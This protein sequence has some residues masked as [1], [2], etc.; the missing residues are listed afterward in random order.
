MHKTDVEN[1]GYQDAA[2]DAPPP[3]MSDNDCTMATGLP[4]CDVAAGMCVQCLGSGDCSGS[5]AI[6]NLGTHMCAGCVT[7]A[8]CTT[9]GAC[10]LNGTCADA[11]AVLYVDG[12]AGSNA[13]TC[14]KAAPCKT[15]TFAQSVAAGKT[16][17]KLANTISDVVAIPA[18]P[19]VFLADPS[20]KITNA[21]MDVVT[22]AAGGDVTMV[23]V[24]VDCALDAKSGITSA[25]ATLRLHHITV[26]NCGKPAILT[27]MAGTLDLYA[28]TIIGNTGG[29]VMAD[30]GTSIDIENNFIV[31]NGNTATQ[32]P[33]GFS[34]LATNP[35]NNIFQFNTVVGN[36]CMKTDAMHSGGV[37]CGALNTLAMPNN[38]V[39]GNVDQTGASDTIL[40]GCDF[41]GSLMDLTNVHFAGSNDYHLLPTSTGAIDKAPDGSTIDIDVDG[42]HRPFGS[43]KDYGADEYT[44]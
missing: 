20:A 16:I 42:E 8:D 36:A 5:N 30:K 29:G 19:I 22:V 27:T 33:G 40:T 34:W 21:T 3:C 17:Y 38:I 4:R 37:T 18:G 35:G 14:T 39:A 32:G 9:S 41:T 1:C 2:I 44:P 11:A 13:G 28:S 23:G 7:N 6:C 43:G 31:K 25:S 12:S 26:T 24:T 15:I 10:L